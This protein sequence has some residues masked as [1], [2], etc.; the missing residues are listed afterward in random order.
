MTKETFDDYGKLEIQNLKCHPDSYVQMCLQ[1]AYVSLHGKPAPCYETATTRKF[2]KG[3]TETVR[4]CTTECLEWV[5]SMLD[6]KSK[7]N[8]Y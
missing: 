6:N 3:R 1:L 4:S 7:V 5:A 8:S 2:Y